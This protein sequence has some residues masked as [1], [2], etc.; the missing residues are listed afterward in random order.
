MGWR[1]TNFSSQI[2]LLDVNYFDVPVKIHV[3]EMTTNTH[4][5]WHMYTF[6]CTHGG[7]GW[8]LIHIH[9]VPVHGDE[10]FVLFLHF[11]PG[12]SN[13]IVYGKS[14]WSSCCGADLVGSR[15]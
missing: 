2:M 11:L 10:C 14:E 3:V 15:C 5:L 1:V 6:H 7:N 8:G 4:I 9:I 13:S 12:Q